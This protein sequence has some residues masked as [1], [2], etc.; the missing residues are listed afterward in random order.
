[1]SE[2]GENARMATAPAT[3][4][5]LGR[6]LEP[7]RA[8]LAVALWLQELQ[9]VAGVFDRLL[10]LS[11]SYQDERPNLEYANTTR[12]AIIALVDLWAERGTPPLL[13]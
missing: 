6:D 7:W 2:R 3:A 8:I 13:R 12:L 1:M 5:L 4:M 11:Q 10:K 9:G